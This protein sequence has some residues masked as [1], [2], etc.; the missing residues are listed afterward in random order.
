MPGEKKLRKTF[1]IQDAV[2]VADAVPV[3]DSGTI[4]A[5]SVPVDN[6]ED[7]YI[8]CEFA[9]EL[10]IHAGLVERPTTQSWTNFFLNFF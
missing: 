6:I 8:V 3:T 7:D 2:P 10:A 1:V 9:Q 5:D 4:I